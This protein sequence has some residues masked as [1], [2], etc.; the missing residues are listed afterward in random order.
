VLF[1]DYLSSDYNPSTVA[2][3]ISTANLA[4]LV[5]SLGG[6]VQALSDFD[7]E[8]AKAYEVQKSELGR[9][10]TAEYS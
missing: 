4:V 8:W 6:S 10:G 5:L 1:Y 3:V 7:R 9:Y 2:R